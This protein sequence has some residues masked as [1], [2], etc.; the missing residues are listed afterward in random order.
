MEKQSVS[1]FKECMFIVIDSYNKEDDSM[2]KVLIIETS[3][4]SLKN[5][6]NLRYRVEWN[7]NSQEWDV[8]S[9]DENYYSVSSQYLIGWFTELC[10][11]DVVE[12]ADWQCN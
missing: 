7:P 4:P 10:A 3:L 6:N 9:T 5:K 11:L 1:V 2:E 12:N 8:E